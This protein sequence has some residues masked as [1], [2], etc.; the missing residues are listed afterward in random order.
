STVPG[1]PYHPHY[2]FETVTIVQKGLVD[3]ADSM[4]AA[5]RFGNGDVQWMTAGGGVN[6]SEMFPLHNPNEPNPFLLF[7]IWLNLP[8]ES[9]KVDPHFKMLWHEDIPV[10]TINDAN[11]N[12]TKITVIAGEL[13]TSKAPSPAPNSWAANPKNGVMI[14]TIN[15]E[16]HAEW[17]LPI[18]N[19]EANR[20][21][22]FFKGSNAEFD[23]QLVE[24]Q[25]IIE[26]NA[27][28]VT[29]IKNGSEEAHFLLLQGKPINEPVVTYGPF[30]TNSNAEMQEVM[31]EYQRTQF[32]GWPWPKS[33]QVHDKSKG[34]FAKHADGKLE[35]KS[36]SP[37]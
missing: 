20:S 32:G 2:G 28:S 21:L 35:E 29:K 27:E 15:M 26:T 6:H 13:D 24:S 10:V 37:I 36:L 3:H 30:V 19:A 34:R 25:R 4:G 8:K 22:Y 9:K 14:F 23:G 17:E 1:F 33:D 18:S 16:P 7:Q 11:G 5:G 31:R 12:T